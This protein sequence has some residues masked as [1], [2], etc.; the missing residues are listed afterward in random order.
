MVRC[1]H[2]S[3]GIINICRPSKQGTKRN[4]ERVSERE[5]KERRNEKVHF[6][7]RRRR[8]T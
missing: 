3:E 7:E 8:R 5:H 4:V 2:I 6:S 1:V